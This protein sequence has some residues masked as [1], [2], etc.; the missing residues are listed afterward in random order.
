MGGGLPLGSISLG[1]LP[2]GILLG[3]FHHVVFHRGSSIR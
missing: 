3:V 2:T 1:G